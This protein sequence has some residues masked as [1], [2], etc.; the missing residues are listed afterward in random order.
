MDITK[1]T[2][3]LKEREEYCTE[4]GHCSGYMKACKIQTPEGLK[5]EHRY[6]CLHCFQLEDYTNVWPPYQKSCDWLEGLV[7]METGMWSLN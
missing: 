4:N 3:R 7:A 1:K 5:E 2:E 6:F